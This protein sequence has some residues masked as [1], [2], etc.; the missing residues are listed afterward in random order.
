MMQHP[1]FL[2][3]DVRACL[4]HC[5]MFIGVACLPTVAWGPSELLC[6]FITRTGP[7]VVGVLQLIPSARLRASR[8]MQ[9]MCLR[10]CRLRWGASCSRAKAQHHIPHGRQII[11]W[12]RRRNKLL[13]ILPSVISLRNPF[14]L[15][16]TCLAAAATCTRADRFQA[17]PP[18]AIPKLRST[19]TYCLFITPRR[20]RRS[21][22]VC[23]DAMQSL[24]CRADA[25]M[26]M[27]MRIPW[28]CHMDVILQ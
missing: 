17:A 9:W 28:L 1:L 4:H 8:S 16:R 18:A 2:R 14:R 6:P 27:C 7:T 5:A 3:V 19:R 20:R 10:A 13:R 22:P 11:S 23:P 25:C 26:G 15:H 21:L 12:L 24:R